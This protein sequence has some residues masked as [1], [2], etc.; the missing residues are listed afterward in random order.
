MKKLL[1]L[2]LVLTSCTQS[3]PRYPVGTCF[4]SKTGELAG[5]AQRINKIG[6]YSYLVQDTEGNILAL[7]FVNE[8]AVV[9][10]DCFNIKFKEEKKK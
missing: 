9:F 8:Y 6:V 7:P 5:K 4:F 2:I 10:C 1:L 3:P